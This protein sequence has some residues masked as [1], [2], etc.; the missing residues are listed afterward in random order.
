MCDR[1]GSCA[2][3]T[4]TVTVTAVSDPPVAA[5]DTAATDGLAVTIPVLANDRDAD[6]DVLR[7]RSVTDP[8]NG[9]ATVNADGTITYTPVA[10]FRG[11]DV[12]S[13][14]IEDANGNLA[15]ARISVTVDP[16][17]SVLPGGEERPAP[18]P[19]PSEPAPAPAP[20][21]KPEKPPERGR[22]PDTRAEPPDVLA[23]TSERDA[24]VDTGASTR[25]V[26]LTGVACL[27]LGL[28]L[29]RSRYR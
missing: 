1:T 19:E 3:A 14:T 11:T 20:E 13:Y 26:A 25:P 23:E 17:P 7:V 24:V 22:L 21:P 15:T 28:L 8:A 27:I 12:F 10:G 18:Q 4:V 6:G 5:D 9:T 2:R 16:P 29:R